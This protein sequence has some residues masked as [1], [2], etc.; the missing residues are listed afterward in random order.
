MPAAQSHVP[1]RHAPLHTHTLPPAWAGREPGVGPAAA[2]SPRAPT[3]LMRVV[4]G[5]ARAAAGLGQ[6]GLHVGAGAGQRG[7]DAA[8]ADGEEPVTPA[9]MRAS[10]HAHTHAQARALRL[11]DTRASKQYA[12]HGPV[13]PAAEGGG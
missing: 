9:T 13:A 7:R 5:P 8:V 10:S 2:H 1:L 12:K 4:T 3:V 6:L 11:R